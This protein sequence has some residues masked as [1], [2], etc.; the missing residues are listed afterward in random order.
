MA[1]KVNKPRHNDP[2]EVLLRPEANPVLVREGHAI[3]VEQ[4][5]GCARHGVQAAARLAKHCELVGVQVA[6]HAQQQLGRQVQ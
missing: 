1:W 4:Q 6:R 5:H 2:L 3:Q